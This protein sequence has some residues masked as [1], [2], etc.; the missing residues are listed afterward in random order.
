LDELR[1]TIFKNIYF[2]KEKTSSTTCD[3][4]HPYKPIG[5]MNY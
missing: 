1:R 5:I 4:F 3:V 2:F